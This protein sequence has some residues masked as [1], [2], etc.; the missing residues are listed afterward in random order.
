MCYSILCLWLQGDA[1]VVATEDV[2]PGG[3]V[4]VVVIVTAGDNAD[5][6]ENFIKY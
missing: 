2:S 1:T 3:G 5:G 4:P 6:C